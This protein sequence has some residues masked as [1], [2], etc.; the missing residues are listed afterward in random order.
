MNSDNEIHHCSGA[1]GP[2]ANN[3]LFSNCTGALSVI[4]LP[5]SCGFLPN[6]A[7]AWVG[8]PVFSLTRV[9]GGAVAVWQFFLSLIS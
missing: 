4:E 2:E 5:M 7:K 3:Y 9:V 8:P 6:S 1:L